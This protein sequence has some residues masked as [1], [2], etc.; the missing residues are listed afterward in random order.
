MA[1][2]KKKK[3]KKP[4]WRTG[5]SSGYIT[6]LKQSIL[7]FDIYDICASRF[8]PVHRDSSMHIEILNMK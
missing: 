8:P 7:I 2:P 1:A 6:N 5:A 4:P 3:K